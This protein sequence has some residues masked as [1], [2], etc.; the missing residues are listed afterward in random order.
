M[1]TLYLPL[2]KERIKDFNVYGLSQEKVSERIVKKASNFKAINFFGQAI[3][4]LCANWRGGTT[5]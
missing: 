1:E 3:V 4:L 2:T 5:K